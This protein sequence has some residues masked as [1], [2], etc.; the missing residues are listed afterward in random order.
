MLSEVNLLSVFKWEK[1]K[2]WDVLVKA[3]IEEFTPEEGV[4]LHIKTRAFHS[5]SDFRRALEKHFGKWT[6]QR[7]RVEVLGEE[8]P[9]TDLPSRGGAHAHVRFRTGALAEVLEQKVCL[10]CQSC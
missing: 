6:A 3:F 9:L 7:P 2:G 4:V 5:S 10:S 1:R 8:L